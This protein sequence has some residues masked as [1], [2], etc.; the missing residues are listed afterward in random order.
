MSLSRRPGESA[1]SRQRGF[2]SK[3]PRRRSIRAQSETCSP[4]NG[5]Y[6][7]TEVTILDQVV[8]NLLPYREGLYTTAEGSQ[9]LASTRTMDIHSSDHPAKERADE[10]YRL[11]ARKYSYLTDYI[12][13]LSR[14]SEVDQYAEALVSIADALGIDDLSFLSV[15]SAIS[16]LSAEELA[17]KRSLL[18]LKHAEEELAAHLAKAKHEE[19]L[20]SKW[21]EII[22]D[23]SNSENSVAVLERR[24]AALMTKAR[25]YQKE[26]DVVMK[27]M[28]AAPP[29]SASELTAYH[30]RVRKKEQELKEK[31]ARVQAFQGLPPNIELARHELRK[32]RDEQM[33]F[34]GKLPRGTF[35]QLCA[36]G[37]TAYLPG[38]VPRTAAP[39]FPSRGTAEGEITTRKGLIG[40]GR[41]PR[42]ADELPISI[43]PTKRRLLTSKS[44]SVSIA[45]PEKET[46]KSSSPSVQYELLNRF[47]P[48]TP[49]SPRISSPLARSQSLPI[50]PNHPH[51]RK[52]SVLDGQLQLQDLRPP[53]SLSPFSPTPNASTS[54]FSLSLDPIAESAAASPVPPSTPSFPSPLPDAA[55]AN[56]RTQLPVIN[57]P[58]APAQ[59]NG[60]YS[61]PPPTSTR[62]PA[63]RPSQLG[64]GPHLRAS[65]IYSRRAQRPPS[66]YA[67]DYAAPGRGG[68]GRALAHPAPPPRTSAA[69]A[70][71]RRRQHGHQLISQLTEHLA[72]RGAARL[73]R[74]LDLAL[75]GASLAALPEHSYAA[76]AGSAALGA[77][78]PRAHAVCVLDVSPS[79]SSS[80]GL[81]LG[82]VEDEEDI[83]PDAPLPTFEVQ[84]SML[85][86][87]LSLAPGESR[88]YTYT[89][90]LPENLPPTFRG[91][92]LRFSYQFILGI[93]RAAP[94]GP[95][96]GP[97]GAN[98]SSRVMKVPIRVYNNVTVGRPPTPYDLLWP[99]VSWKMRPRPPGKVVEEQKTPLKKLR[100]AP[101]ISSPGIAF[102]ESG[103]F[104]DMQ[105]YARNLL[106]S[107]P[108][109]NTR[110]VRI[111]LPIEAIQGGIKLDQVRE[112]EEQGSPTGCR[113]AV[114]LLTRNPKKA[115]YDVN[116]DGVKVAVLTFTNTEAFRDA[117]GARISS[118]LHFV[119]YALETHAARACGAPLVLY[120][121]DAAYD[122]LA[123]HPPDASPAFQVDVSEQAA[124]P[125]KR[126]APHPGGL[127]WKVRLCLLVA[128][129]SPGARDGA[130]GVRLRHLVRDGPNGHWGSSW[131]AAPT[132][133]PMERPETRAQSANGAEEQ[134]PATPSTA[135][136]WMS[137]FAAS[138]LGPSNV[139][140]HDGDED[141]DEEDGGAEGEDGEGTWKDV[142]V[143]MVEC[144][145]PIRVWPGN[146]AFKATD[147]VFNV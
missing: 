28:P 107:F 99:V 89:I 46:L 47:K 139:G 64:H 128:V 83:D 116:K 56:V 43:D 100:K 63:R 73:T 50:A 14:D 44:L 41:P 69:A 11:R 109:P 35:H 58:D 42:G 101:H 9:L 4:A 82:T 10:Y 84:P 62:G 88:S 76:I 67:D 93:C 15:S 51:A 20:I 8:R 31:R 94:A 75:C 29:L 57:N 121:R 96:A 79:P 112:R 80:V 5:E 95:T 129:A 141:I 131:K 97:A 124:S 36:P 59:V 133:A 60:T 27:D 85:A 22:N 6:S 92:A 143:E 115:S 117:R 134:V 91:R 65:N 103:T 78:A 45:S 18:R 13:I 2:Q 142:K 1:G 12:K 24:K 53:T 132:I 61:Y 102:S 48:V 108:D 110:G 7:G 125:S 111:K 98:S 16:R 86:V 87:D 147:V 21:T 77:V 72:T 74:P 25:E 32:A 105:E 126:N 136:E 104:E 144:E 81:G 118:E 38:T 130:E 137:Y 123:G 40:R 145:V 23:Q 30:K 3:R 52:Q 138:L 54:T 55:A 26:L 70:G 49:T 19:T 106:A 135:K 140:Y 90:V 114:E 17:L 127:E 39:T 71:R 37:T 119:T 66:G 113:Q 120:A 33:H 34:P 68:G 122:V 146:T